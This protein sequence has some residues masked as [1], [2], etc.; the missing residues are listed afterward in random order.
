MS[1]YKSNNII[2]VTE[3]E[4]DSQ[5]RGKSRNT[6]AKITS[7]IDIS[8]VRETIICGKLSGFLFRSFMSGRLSIISKT[9]LSS[10]INGFTSFEQNNGYGIYTYTNIYKCIYLY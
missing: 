10:L 1:F 5:R 3:S 7:I 6:C 4:N 8:R 9:W 2:G